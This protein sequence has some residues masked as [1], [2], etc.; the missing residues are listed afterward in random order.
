LYDAVALVVSDAAAATLA[1]QPAARDFVA[2]AFSHSK[3]IGH[4]GAAAPLLDAAGVASKIDEGFVVLD[5]DG[6]GQFLERCRD[7][8]FWERELLVPVMQ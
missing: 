6:A 4:V 8:R 5:G 1:E 7:V 3:F 2:D